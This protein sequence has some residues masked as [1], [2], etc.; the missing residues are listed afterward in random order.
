MCECVCTP[1]PS[2]CHLGCL[3]PLS[4]FAVPQSSPFPLPCTPEPSP[5]LPA[6]PKTLRVFQWAQSPPSVSPCSPG[7]SM[8]FSESPRLRFWAPHDPPRDFSR[9][10]QPSTC[11]SLCPRSLCP[12]FGASPG[13]LALPLIPRGQA[14][15][16]ESRAVGWASRANV[17]M[18][19]KGS[20]RVS[21]RPT[22]RKGPRHP[23]RDRK[24][25][26]GLVI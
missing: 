14:A 12:A 20:H 1:E 4:M 16:W 10:L 25:S 26:G 24:G 5:S 2:R 11:L 8:S 15:R 19:E 17:L 9:A 7:L 13:D 21:A 23:R 6:P 18:G 22:G 3:S